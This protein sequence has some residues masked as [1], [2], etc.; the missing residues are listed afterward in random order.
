MTTTPMRSGRAVLPARPHAGV[1]RRRSC[2]TCGENKNCAHAGVRGQLWPPDKAPRVGGRVAVYTPASASVRGHGAA[3]SEPRGRCTTQCCRDPSI[4]RRQG[5]EPGVVP[6]HS[7]TVPQ[8]GAAS[9]VRAHRVWVVTVPEQESAQMSAAGNLNVEA[10]AEVAPT[11][12][13]VA[14]PGPAATEA[15]TESVNWRERRPGV[16]ACATVYRR[17]GRRP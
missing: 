16:R 7:T 10:Y 13:G 6:C 5:A 15:A 1:A 9:P 3:A 12:E 8:G 17:A 2:V 11:G 14:T 4:R